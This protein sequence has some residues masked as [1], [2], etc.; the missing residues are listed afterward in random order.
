MG[1]ILAIIFISLFITGVFWVGS[2]EFSIHGHSSITPDNKAFFEEK[3]P[4][5]LG[6]VFRW[7]GVGQPVI[8]DIILI[9]KDGTKVGNDDKRISI[10]VY[11]SEQGIGAVDEGTAIDEGYFEQY[12][13][14]EDFKVTNKILF[15]VLRVELKDESFENDIEQMLIEFKMMNFNRAKYIDFP[16]IVDET[17]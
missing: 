8:Q 6:Y 16:G 12:L 13:P 7:N 10:K 5:H 11:I 2:G 14:V 17:N 3:K 4:F 9:K 1:K 15:L